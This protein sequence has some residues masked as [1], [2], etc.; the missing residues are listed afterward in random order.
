MADP[1][2]DVAVIGEG[3]ELQGRFSGQ[4]LLVLGRFDGDV[5]LKGRL[6]I[7]P[8]GR[9]KV[10]VRA[11]SI[12]VEGELEGDVKTDALSLMPSARVR[13]TFQAKR[14]TVQEGALLEGSINPVKAA[15][16]APPPSPLAP[17]TVRVEGDDIYVLRG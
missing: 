4:D 17:Y 10:N 8:K 7:G 9:A 13:G 14:L 12:E 16:P 11:A 3:A 15:P 6:R 5:E 2:K 1:A